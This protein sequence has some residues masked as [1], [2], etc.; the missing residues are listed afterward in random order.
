MCTFFD[1]PR[2]CYP[3]SF[4]AAWILISQLLTIDNTYRLPGI[5][6]NQNRMKYYAIISES[7][8]LRE[9]YVKF[10]SVMFRHNTSTGSRVKFRQIDKF[11]TDTLE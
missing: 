6:V 4:I 8:L 10:K 11:R 1:Q 7:E 3:R 2:V 5:Y 9:V